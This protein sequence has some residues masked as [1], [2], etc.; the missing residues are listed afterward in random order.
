MSNHFTTTEL[1]E[2]ARGALLGENAESLLAHSLRCD[3]CGTRLAIILALEEAG[4]AQR[5]TTSRRRW[6]AAA[7]GM[8]FVGVGVM[9]VISMRT[10]AELP[11]HE[12]ATNSH[13]AQLATTEFPSSRGF[14]RIRFGA[15]RVNA[16][17]WEPRVKNAV[18]ALWS[19]NL[20]NA[21]DALKELRAERPEDPEIA[22]YLGIALY[23]SG[24]QDDVVRV[25]LIEGAATEWQTLSRYS[26]FYL[27]N[28]YLRLEIDLQAI[29][30]L[31]DL[32]THPDSPGESAAALLR[33]LQ[34]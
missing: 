6:L 30:I 3:D 24:Q 5:V 26:M 33:Q 16:S 19:G 25:L 31:S 29:E 22:A 1:I 4:S 20:E 17:N 23:L 15:I 32:A 10:P 9:V 12:R 28:H 13:F 27:A 34:R 14:L 18:E 21:L 11:Q 8:A 2:Y 7:A